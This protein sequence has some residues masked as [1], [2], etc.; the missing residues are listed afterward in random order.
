MIKMEEFDDENSKV[1]LPFYKRKKY[2]VIG[3]RVHP[4]ESNSSWMMQGFI[5]A[6]LGNSH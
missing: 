2:V 1:S 6:L 4:G 3:S 5:K